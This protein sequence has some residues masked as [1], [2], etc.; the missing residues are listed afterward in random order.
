MHVVSELFDITVNDF[1]GKKSTRYSRVLVVTELVVSWTQHMRFYQ[2][3]DPTAFT[4][5]HAV[6][7]NS[8]A[9]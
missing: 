3:T 9:Y 7:S 8:T 4:L 5:F 1:D 2:E 6:L